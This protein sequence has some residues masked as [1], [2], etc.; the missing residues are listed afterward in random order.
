MVVN[1]TYKGMKGVFVRYVVQSNGEKTSSVVKLERDI[2][3]QRTLR[4]A[5]VA[6]DEEDSDNEP[7]GDGDEGITLTRQEFKGLKTDIQELEY[8]LRELK[9]QLDAIESRHR[10][11]R[12]KRRGR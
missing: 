1:G 10:R 5:S 8:Q 4:K 7:D 2:K 6:L 9:D 3:S 12:N 11:K